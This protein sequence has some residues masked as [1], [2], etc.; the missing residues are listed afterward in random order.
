M[1]G[2]RKFVSVL[3]EDGTKIVP[4]GD[5]FSEPPSEMS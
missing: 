4:P 3:G 5:I 1:G 2:G